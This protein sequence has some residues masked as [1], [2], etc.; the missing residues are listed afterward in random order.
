[1][2]AAMTVSRLAGLS[3]QRYKLP[4]TDKVYPLFLQIKAFADEDSS[5]L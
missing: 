3:G 2:L 4:T 5:I 1:M